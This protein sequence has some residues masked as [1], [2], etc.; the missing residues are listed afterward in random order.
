MTRSVKH[1]SRLG[2]TFTVRCETPQFAVLWV[3]DVSLVEEVVFSVL[4][5]AAARAVAGK[6]VN[7]LRPSKS[8]TLTT[9]WMPQLF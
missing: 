3:A 7:Q 2:K 1:K 9:T 6:S 4:K 5:D 8:T